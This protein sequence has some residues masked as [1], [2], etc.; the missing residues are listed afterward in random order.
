MSK[1]DKFFLICSILGLCLEVLISFVA[2]G[3]SRPLE[4]AV[5]VVIYLVVACS[6]ILSWISQRLSPKAV[7]VAEGVRSFLILVLM[8]FVFV[9]NVP[10]IKAWGARAFYYVQ[11][12][13]TLLLAALSTL[14]LVLLA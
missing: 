8:A 7:A 13:S 10:A 4:T 2:S 11:N 1:S 5:R 6:V 14:A 3:Q 12:H 9:E